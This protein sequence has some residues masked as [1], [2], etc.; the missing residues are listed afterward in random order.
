[1]TENVGRVSGHYAGAFTRLGAFF[2]DW[3][4]IVFTYG[5]IVY[6]TGRLL[7]FFFG[8]DLDTSQTTALPYILGFLFWAYIY[9]VMGMTIAGRAIG[10]GIVGLRVVTRQ[11]APVTFRRASL[12]IFALPLSFLVFGLGFLGIIVGKERRALHDV[13]AGTAVVYDWGDRQASMPAPLTR[14]LERRG[15]GL[16]E[17]ELAEELTA[18]GESKTAAAAGVGAATDTDG[19]E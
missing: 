16:T 11:G 2:I 10:K 9:L 13:I 19:E 3:F 8:V 4:V 17:P 12:R 15:V 18:P 14:W 1:M 6:L 5:I 7:D